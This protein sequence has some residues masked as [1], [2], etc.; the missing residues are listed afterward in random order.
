MPKKT[1]P[2]AVQT[3]L[4]AEEIFREV[5]LAIEPDLVAEESVREAKYQGESSEAHQQRLARYEAAFEEYF[6]TIDGMNAALTEQL[7]EKGRERRKS[8][9]A[10]EQQERETEAAQAEHIADQF[11]SQA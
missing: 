3:G 4:S 6:R 5:M 9:H 11:S 1:K 8:L 7:Y 2:I 10:S